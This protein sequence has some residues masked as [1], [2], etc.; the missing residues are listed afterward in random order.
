[1]TGDAGGG[2]AMAGCAFCTPGAVETILT[3]TPRLRLVADFAPV[4]EGHMLIVPR[5]HFP[6]YG[7]VPLTYEA[8]LVALKRRVARFF[9]ETYRPAV[10]FEHGVFRQTVFHAHLH[11]FP[12]GAVGLSLADLAVPDGQPVHGL[13]DLRAWYAAHGHY[14]YVE[15]PRAAGEPLEAR[16]FP[17][18]EERYYRALGALR[19]QSGRAGGWRPAIERRATASPVIAA[20]AAAWRA[21]DRAHPTESASAGGTAAVAG[22]VEH[23][24]SPDQ[25][26]DDTGSRST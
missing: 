3:E 12:F 26:A 11:A 4:V 6:C 22:A 21:F 18:E 25:R 19:E 10:F 15:A 7:A 20:L 2:A 13:A 1:M 16:V 8:E 17:P 24:G 23:A 14:F 5:E 9:R